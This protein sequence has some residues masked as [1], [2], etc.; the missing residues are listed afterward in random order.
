[1]ERIGETM[2]TKLKESEEKETN[3]EEGNKYKRGRHRE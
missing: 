3:K 2:T 1:V